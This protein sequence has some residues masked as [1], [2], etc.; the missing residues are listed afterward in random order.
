MTRMTTR[1][2]KGRS[3]DFAQI[4]AQVK[5]ISEADIKISFRLKV[6]S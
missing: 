6:L 1:V 2:V 5:H 3:E 4:K